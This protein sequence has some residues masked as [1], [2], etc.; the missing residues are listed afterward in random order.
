MNHAEM[1]GAVLHDAADPESA[2]RALAILLEA[3]APSKAEVRAAGFEPELV[4][5]LKKALPADV[6]TREALCAAGAAWVQG[7]RSARKDESWELV[8]SIAAPLVL[9]PGARRAT[10]ETLIGLVASAKKLVRIAAPFMD[11]TGMGHLVEPLAAATTRGVQVELLV[12][13]RSEHQDRALAALISGL[14][15][16][17]AREHLRVFRVAQSAPWPHLKVLIADSSAAYIGSANLTGPGMGGRNVEL[18]VLV[19]GAQVKV[20]D[21]L[22]DSIPVG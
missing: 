2:A 7:R 20:I 11:E 13:Y 9:P 17:G 16:G 15:R 8:L 18:G 1:I 21:L 14:E 19:K 12:S 10:A 3:T 6:H 5:A 22:L 4:M